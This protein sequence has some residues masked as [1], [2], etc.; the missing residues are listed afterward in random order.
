MKKRLLLAAM[1]AGAF[2][3]TGCNTVAGFGEDLKKGSR[4]VSEAL[5]RAG[6]KLTRSAESHKAQ[7]KA[8]SENDL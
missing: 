3:L 5:G 1:L 4:E 6:D 2:A 7:S 8:D